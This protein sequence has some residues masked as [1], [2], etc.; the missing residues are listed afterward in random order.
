MHNSQCTYRR[1]ADERRQAD[2]RIG[3]L[4]CNCLYNGINK[5]HG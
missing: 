1:S 3:E 5:Q 4:L 2:I